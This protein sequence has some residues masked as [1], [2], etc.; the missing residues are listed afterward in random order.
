MI[1]EIDRK[2]KKIVVHGNETVVDVPFSKIG[3]LKNYIKNQKVKV[4][5]SVSS[6]S[7]N[8]LIR[9]LKAG[10][11]APV[12]TQA[13]SP[14]KPVNKIQ[15]PD[16]RDRMYFLRATKPGVLKIE[17]IKFNDQYDIKVIDELMTARIKKSLKMQSAIK[18]GSLEVINNQ[19]RKVLSQ[20][21]KLL[22]EKQQQEQAARDAQLDKIIVD[23]GDT[24]A[25]MGMST[26]STAE[27]RRSAL[28]QAMAM[29][30][31]TGAPKGPVIGSDGYIPEEGAFDTMSDLI[32]AIGGGS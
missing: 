16:D 18:R 2:N 8:D 31:T 17:G 5:E 6:L 9:T 7:Y 13:K 21:K 4:T 10:K 25:I 24:E 26:L 19:Q 30:N 12:Q 11:P 15:K 29:I 23:I 3:I 1:L 28:K 27:S 32:N 14:D 22:L 20:G